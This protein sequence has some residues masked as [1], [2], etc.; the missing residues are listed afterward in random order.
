MIKELKLINLIIEHFIPDEE[1]NK[2][3]KKLDFSEELDDWVIK[4]YGHEDL[5]V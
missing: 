2:L 1:V 5:R 3:K 4:D